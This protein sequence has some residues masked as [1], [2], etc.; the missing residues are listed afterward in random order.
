MKFLKNPAQRERIKHLIIESGVFLMCCLVLASL[1]VY[2]ENAY[3]DQT[4]KSER[5]YQ[6][7]WC[8][9]ED[10]VMEY[11][12]D[13]RTRVD[14]L[15]DTYAIEFDF[16]RKWYQAVGQSLH[17]A[18]QTGRKAAGIV[19]IIEKPSDAKYWIRLKNIIDHF[20][21]PIHIWKYEL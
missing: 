1:W 10:G 9:R 4:V 2:T 20:G 14:C 3:G 19:L 8:N 12:N 6:E 13:D 5:Y 7:I 15:T 17:Y 18:M 11:V 16:A 21:L